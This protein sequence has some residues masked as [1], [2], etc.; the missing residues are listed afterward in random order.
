VNTLDCRGMRCPLPVIE[1]AKLWP[2]VEVGDVVEVLADDA[3]AGPDL[4]AWCRLKEQAFEGSPSPGAFR[5][6]RL[7]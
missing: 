5:V 7:S 4:E 1:L 3:A 2:S 6:R